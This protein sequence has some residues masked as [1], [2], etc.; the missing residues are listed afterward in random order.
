[1]ICNHDFLKFYSDMV[2]AI[3]PFFYVQRNAYK[4]YNDI[5]SSF[6][7]SNRWNYQRRKGRFEEK[8]SKS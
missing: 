2:H 6:K 5:G 8:P 7:Q 3:F 4:Y 1:M